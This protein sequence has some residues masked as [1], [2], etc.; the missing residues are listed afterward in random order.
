MHRL[1]GCTASAKDHVGRKS[2][3]FG[4][5]LVKL[6]AI[7]GAPTVIDSQIAADAPARILQPLLEGRH[8]ELRFRVVRREVH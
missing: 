4:G 2:D 1:R 3:E 6:L 8:V 7:E 5:L